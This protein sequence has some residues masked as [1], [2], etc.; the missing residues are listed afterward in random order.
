MGRALMRTLQGRARFATHA[1]LDVT[2]EF[3]V[4]AAL[5]GCELVV[6]AA[7]FTDVDACEREAERAWAVNAIGTQN[8]ARHAQALGCPVLYLSTDFVF[9]G[10]VE[11]A[12]AEDDPPSPVN[13][14][15]RSKLAGEDAVRGGPHCI[16]RTSWVF[17]DGKNFVRSILQAAERGHSRLDVVDDQ[18]GRPTYAA[19][20]AIA[21]AQAAERKL[22][23]TF[24]VA[25]DGAPVTRAELARNALHMTDSSTAV[26]PVTTQEYAQMAERPLAPRPPRSVLSLEKARDHG[27]HLRDWRS[28]LEEYVAWG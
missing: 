7:A 22:Q 17:G 16:I 12:Y 27:L 25:G 3:H 14:Y 10:S 18:I 8:I 4:K 23:G 28:G 1:D 6:H 26:N 2:E 20:L 21:V 19:D 9:D 15:G 11:D 13:E 5:D 24:H